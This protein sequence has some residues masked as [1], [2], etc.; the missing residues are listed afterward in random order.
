MYFDSLVLR[1]ELIS[2][3]TAFVSEYHPVLLVDTSCLDVNFIYLLTALQEMADPG[4]LV[5]H[6]MQ[7]EQWLFQPQS[8]ISGVFV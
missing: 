5:C 1:D 3:H 7:S 8:C 4:L 6:D 2:S